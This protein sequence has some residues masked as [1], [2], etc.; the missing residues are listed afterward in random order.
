MGMQRKI[1]SRSSRSA[2]GF[3]LL[4]SLTLI[5]ILLFFSACG[6]AAQTT[7]PHAKST[8]APSLST[9]SAVS[10]AELK[11]LQQQVFFRQVYGPNA[12]M[13]HVTLPTN[14]LVVY[15]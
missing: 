6:G 13:W 3:P 2:G 8:V 15:Y 5:G 9:H 1:R 7:R 4:L 11:Y 10:A 12:W 14:R